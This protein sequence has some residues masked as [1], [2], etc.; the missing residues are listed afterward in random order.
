MEYVKCVLIWL[1]HI[2]NIPWMVEIENTISLLSES[3]DTCGLDDVFP[4]DDLYSR[5]EALF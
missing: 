4:P 2:L 3:T 5:P 1:V